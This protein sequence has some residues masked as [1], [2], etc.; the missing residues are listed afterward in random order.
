MIRLPV[1]NKYPKSVKHDLAKTMWY[2]MF[3]DGR[4][5]LKQGDP[6]TRMYFI[7]S[8]EVD[9]FRTDVIKEGTILYSIYLFFLPGDQRR[10]VILVLPRI[11]HLYSV[12]CI[13]II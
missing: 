8:G 7:I 5:I 4:V 9:L 6:G 13:Y 11:K 10:C 3:K 1:F 2:D 12:H